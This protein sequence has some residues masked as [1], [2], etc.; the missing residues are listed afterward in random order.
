MQQ[1][2]CTSAWQKL[3]CNQIR[4]GVEALSA[5]TVAVYPHHNFN[6]SIL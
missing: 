3:N 6:L 1:V 5:Q 4:T 2:I